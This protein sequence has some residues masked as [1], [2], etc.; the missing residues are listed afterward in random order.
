M[1]PA[2]NR[3]P[4]RLAELRRWPRTTARSPVPATGN[5]AC[6]AFSRPSRCASR[7]PQPSAEPRPDKRPRTPPPESRRLA[8]STTPLH[9]SDGHPRRTTAAPNGGSCAPA[10]DQR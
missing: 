10:V 4:A 8:R 1:P 2:G 9:L 3:A 6:H 7:Y 5:G